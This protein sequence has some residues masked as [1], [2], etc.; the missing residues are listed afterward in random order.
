MS[1]SSDFISQ[2]QPRF[3]R[4]VLKVDEARSKLRSIAPEQLV[5]RSGCAFD[6]TNQ[7]RLTFFGR[8]YLISLAD[9]AVR[10]ADNGEEPASFTQDLILTYLHLA[11]GAPGTI[12]G[13]AFAIYRTVYFTSGRFKA[14]P[15]Q[16]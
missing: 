6:Q 12:S 15:A 8:D 11:D 3:E 4:L 2:L 16:N 14:T 7:L 13:S 9:F 5:A 10:R 1:K